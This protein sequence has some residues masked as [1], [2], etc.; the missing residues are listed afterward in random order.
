MMAPEL[1]KLAAA[2]AGRL[3]VVKLDVQAFPGIAMRYGI[4]NIPTL[5]LF[6]D[7]EPKERLVG[8]MPLKKIL[9]KLS[10]Y[11]AS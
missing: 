4:M 5:I 9:E 11:L 6:V 1:E 10:P 8:Y 3:N 7:G 2:H